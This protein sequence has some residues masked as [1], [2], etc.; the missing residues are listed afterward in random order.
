VAVDPGPAGRGAGR[1][2][3]CI[4]FSPFLRAKKDRQ[5]IKSV[6][7]GS[8]NSY[9]PV[10]DAAIGFFSSLKTMQAADFQT[11]FG[12]RCYDTPITRGRTTNATSKPS[13]SK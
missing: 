5:P 4:L 1:R 10:F 8:I 7:R 11:F 9:R 3:S 12:D 2:R 13:S 6:G